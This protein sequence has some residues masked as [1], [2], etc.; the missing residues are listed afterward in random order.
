MWRAS[1][2]E[3]TLRLR[4]TEGKRRRGWQRLRWLDKIINSMDMNLSKLPGIVR[5]REAWHAPVHRV[6][7]S[8]TQLSNFTHFQDCANPWKDW[9]WSWSASALATWCEEPTHWKRSWLRAGGE[10]SDRGWDGWMASPIQWTWTW[11]NSGRQCRTRKPGMLQS[12]GSQRVRHNFG[13]KQQQQQ[14]DL[15]N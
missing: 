11:A 13:T 4:K 15:V 8:R 3:K 14:R 6:G 9:C 2:L 7:K 1:S 12:M 5:D 10:G